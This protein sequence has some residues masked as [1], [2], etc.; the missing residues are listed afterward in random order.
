MWRWGCCNSQHGLSLTRCEY[1]YVPFNSLMPQPSTFT[2]G[3]MWGSSSSCMLCMSS[4]ETS[5]AGAGAAPQPPVRRDMRPL[6][7]R[8]VHWQANGGRRSCWLSGWSLSY[9]Q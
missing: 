9:A 5:N 8:T 3:G 2:A 7:L 6:P 4:S 1:T